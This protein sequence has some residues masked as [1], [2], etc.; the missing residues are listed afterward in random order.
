MSILCRH[1]FVCF[2]NDKYWYT[3]QDIIL[4]RHHFVYYYNQKQ[5]SRLSSKPYCIHHF[6]CYYNHQL[7]IH[8]C[9][10]YLLV[11][12]ILYVFTTFLPQLSLVPL[13]SVDIIF[14]CFYINNSKKDAMSLA[15]H[16]NCCF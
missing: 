9:M 15:S 5:T 2:Y 6:V 10:F 8:R 3:Q 7:S 1:H 14:V 12:I 4:C 16:M 11:G 13:S